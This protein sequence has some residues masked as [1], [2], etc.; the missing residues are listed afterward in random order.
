MCFVISSLQDAVIP[1][2]IFVCL[3]HY[4][5]WQSQYKNVKSG[6]SYLLSPVYI[7]CNTNFLVVCYGF[8]EHYRSGYIKNVSKES[9]YS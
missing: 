4:F 5:K 6:H 1:K 8:T 2:S 9:G 3:S 7:M